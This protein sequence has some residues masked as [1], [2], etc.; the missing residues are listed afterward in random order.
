MAT[1][2]Y[3]KRYNKWYVYEVKQ[4]WDKELKKPRQKTKY[5][6]VAKEK[7]GEYSKPNKN[8][9]AATQLAVAKTTVSSNNAI[10]DFGDSYAINE[11]SKTSGLSSII[12]NSF[13]HL[14]SIMALI[15]FQI[16][17]GSA[18]Y[19][20]ENWLDG[21]IASKLFMQVR[22]P[23]NHVPPFIQSLVRGKINTQPK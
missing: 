18:L 3:I 12:A 15:C 5:L 1:I 9:D 23:G 19:N 22:R 20:C 16:T 7:D 13:G 11:I 2:R 8:T 4:Y 17:E 14:D 6:G 21:N 10:V